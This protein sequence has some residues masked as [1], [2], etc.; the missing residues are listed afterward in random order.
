MNKE[1]KEI[2]V[3]FGFLIDWFL[4][5]TLLKIIFFLH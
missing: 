2:I 3:S 5:A 1:K 4:I